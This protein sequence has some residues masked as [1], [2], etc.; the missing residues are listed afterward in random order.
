MAKKISG[1]NWIERGWMRAAMRDNGRLT[2]SAG[3]SCHSAMLLKWVRRGWA[4]RVNFAGQP[5]S[6]G[7]VRIKLTAV[8]MAFVEPEGTE[9][10]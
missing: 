10:A 9:A 5:D 2:A 8:G 1:P 4:V 6:T 3:T 7:P